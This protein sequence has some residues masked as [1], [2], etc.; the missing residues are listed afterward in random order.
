LAKREKSEESEFES[1]YNDVIDS[2]IEMLDNQKTLE[3]A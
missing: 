3:E 1:S 2:W